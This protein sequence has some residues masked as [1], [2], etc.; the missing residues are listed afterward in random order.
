M[1]I[2]VGKKLFGGFFAVL[3]ILIAIVIVS[4]TQINTVHSVY[5]TLVDVEAKKVVMIKDLV[6]E[7]KREQVSARDYLL[8]D[9]NALDKFSGYHDAFQKESNNLDQILTV[10]KTKDTLKELSQIEDEYVQYYNQLFELKKQNPMKMI[11][12]D[13]EEITNKFSKKAKEMT[14]NLQGSLDK[15]NQETSLQVASIK[16]W[17]LMLGLIS[18]VVAF[19][20][21]FYIARIISKPVISLSEAVEKI[22]SG[23]LAL[24]EIKVKNKDEIGDLAKSFNHMVNNLRELI[25]QVSS[26]AEQ[27]AAASEQLSASA[28]QTS[29]ATELI[30]STMQDVATGTENQVHSAERTSQTVNEMSIGI[31]QISSNSQNVSA[32]A[33]QALDKAGEGNES[34]QIAVKQM[35]SIN[36]TVTNL[37]QVISGLGERSKEIEQIIE[38]ITGIASQTNLLA[39]NA[40]IEAARAGEHGRGFAVVADE[41]RKLAEQSSDSAQRISQLIS[42]I[43]TETNKAVQSMEYATKEV[44]EGIGVV[45]TA[46][47]SFEQI[48]QSVSEVAGQIQEVSSAVQQMSAGTEQM[49]HSVKLIREITESTASGTQ[50][51][52]ASTEEQM[53]SM[54]EISSSS[55]SLSKMAEE[56]QTLISKFKV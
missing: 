55:A 53:A 22:A 33:I 26:N 51:V 18:F 56:L 23:D 3:F 47:N 5:S 10:S 21:A 28:E 37:S 43:Q 48:R 46:G 25:H 38:V 52:S 49:V 40:A 32:T 54:E 30:A 12:P 6:L 27:V 36:E 9:E 31:Q 34:I 14:D 35:N 7:I 44:L 13:D 11:N 20:V 15:S 19:F 45:E 50:E 42:A 16:Y 39:L 1:K 41:V 17:I 4:Y 8:G 24:D 2:T 29:K